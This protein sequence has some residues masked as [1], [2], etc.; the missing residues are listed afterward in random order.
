VDGLMNVGLLEGDQE[1][2]IAEKKY[3]RFYMHNSSHWL[4]LDAHD[5]GRRKFGDEVRT[6][7]PG[8]VVTVEPGLYI[9][10]DMAEVG[11]EYRGIGI[12]IEDDVLVTGNGHEVLTDKA[13]KK[14]EDIEGVM[15][16]CKK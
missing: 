2:I 16:H 6:F 4:G 13:P 3:D 5:V 1:K 8:M 10:E 7:E 15:G 14:I 12:R 9:A 11:E